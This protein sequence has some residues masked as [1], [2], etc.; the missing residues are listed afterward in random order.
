MDMEF[1]GLMGGS[2]PPGCNLTEHQEHNGAAQSFPRVGR[3]RVTSLPAGW[4]YVANFGIKQMVM[5]PEATPANV[6]LGEDKLAAPNGLPAYIAAQGKLMEH[7]LAEPK[8][9]GPQITP[10]QGAEEAYL[11]FIRHSVGEAGKMLHAQSYVRSGTWVGIVTL[12]TLESQL[13]TVRPAYES[14]LKGLRILPPPEG[15]P[16]Q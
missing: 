14:F 3:W 7:H 9:A 8:M 10:F 2:D 13:L 16:P 12:T 4:M 5:D 6:S 11:F 15:A 1:D